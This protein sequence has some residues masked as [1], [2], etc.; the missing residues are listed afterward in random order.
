MLKR[1]KLYVKKM[2]NLIFFISIF[3]FKI[4]RYYLFENFSSEYHYRCVIFNQDLVRQSH[5]SYNTNED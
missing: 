3:H 2:K 5:A 1:W 4:E